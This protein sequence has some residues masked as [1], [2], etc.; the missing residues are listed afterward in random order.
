MQV[1]SNITEL[2]A[3]AKE[4][5]LAVTMPSSTSYAAVPQTADSHNSVCF[6]TVHQSTS[7]NKKPPT[8]TS[9]LPKRSGLFITGR[10]EGQKVKFS[11][12]T[13]AE[14]TILSTCI[15]RSFPKTLRSAFQD[16]STRLQLVVGQPLHAQG[17]ILCN[18][19][20]GDKKV[21]EAI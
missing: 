13:G 7:S 10:V 16:K 5:N 3:D 1:S 18:L 19:S 11:V 17:P 15:M 20:I 2:N 14:P 12:D 21:V 6:I 9:V 8:V 4:F